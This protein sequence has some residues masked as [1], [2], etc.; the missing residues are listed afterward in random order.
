MLQGDSRGKTFGENQVQEIITLLKEGNLYVGSDGSENNGRGVYAYGFTSN[1]VEGNI[2][3][4]A[5][6]TP[7]SSQE[8]SSFITEHRGLI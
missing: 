6:L 4:E 7:G 3:G 5:A 1:I 2:W 8:I